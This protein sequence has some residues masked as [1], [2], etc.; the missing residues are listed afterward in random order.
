MKKRPVR[1]VKGLQ[2]ACN[3]QSGRMATL[4]RRPYV[5]EPALARHMARFEALNEIEDS[6]ARF[7]AFRRL[8]SLEF[9]L[10]A[11]YAGITPK[12]RNSLAQRDR[13]RHPRVRVAPDG[14]KLE[15][16]VL[17]ILRNAKDPGKRKAKEY[18]DDL[19]DR[20]EEL[21]LKPVSTFDPA[22]PSIDRLE[23]GVDKRRSL[24][25][26]HFENVVSKVRRRMLS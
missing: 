12:Q 2:R 18:W 22:D 3:A 17:D 24:T 4:Y 8:P 10:N 26:R 1:T 14:R 7:E 16:I 9:D 21:S 11:V 15:A 19:V 23:Y 13:A 6:D 20:L 25:L 5:L